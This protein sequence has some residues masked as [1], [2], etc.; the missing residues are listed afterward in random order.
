MRK[1]QLALAVTLA[2]GCGGEQSD[3]PRPEPT[4]GG[5]DVAAAPEM[6]PPMEEEPMEEPAPEPVG[7]AHLTVTVKVGFDE[8]ELPVRILDADGEEVATGTAGAAFTLPAGDYRVAVAVTDAA[9]LAD[10]PEKQEAV[11]LAPAEQRAL[12]IQCPRAQVRLRVRRHGRELRRARVEL[13]HAGSDETVV[14]YRTSNDYLPI[15]AGRYTAIVHAANQ[16]I[17]VNDMI[18]MEGSSR[19][20][21]I[22]IN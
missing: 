13:R 8:T 10:T 22:D 18:F 4:S 3:E 20:M 15:S 12:Q 5:E 1:I 7:P 16:E 19:D 17:T 2:L 14:D 6:A 9:L 11:S 21:P